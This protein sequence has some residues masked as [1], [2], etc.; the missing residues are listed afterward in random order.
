M[1]IYNLLYYSIIIIITIII[2][3][4]I[5][6]KLLFSFESF[7][8]LK[9]M[10]VLMVKMVRIKYIL[11]KY[12][13]NV[14]FIKIKMLTEKLNRIIIYLAYITLMDKKIECILRN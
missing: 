12:D 2:I 7:V 14:S 8:F 5:Y 6:Q 3:I 13:G 10:A 9:T 1:F 4:Y 11:T